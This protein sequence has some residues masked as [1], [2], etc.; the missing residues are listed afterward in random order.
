[1]ATS[2][3]R[4]PICH[5]VSKTALARPS[6]VSDSAVTQ[7]CAGRTRWVEYPTPTGVGPDNPGGVWAI[8]DQYDGSMISPEWFG[9][10]TYMHDKKGDQVTKGPPPLHCPSPPNI[11]LITARS[12]MAHHLPTIHGSCIAPV[13]QNT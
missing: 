8:E 10:M 7:L 11:L 1:M 13:P 4:T 12:H 5:T 9:W 2:I 6:W 3:L